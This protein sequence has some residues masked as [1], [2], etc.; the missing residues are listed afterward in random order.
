MSYEVVWTRRKYDLMCVEG[1]LSDEDAK[2]LE[3]HIRRKSLLEIATELNYSD[4][5]PIN[6]AIN[7]LKIIYD[8]L[9]KEY[10][11]ILSPRSKS[12]YSKRSKKPI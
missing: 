8:E 9:Q 7:R 6:D 5:D 3:L 11:D 4:V 10:P 1:M 2:I 12:V